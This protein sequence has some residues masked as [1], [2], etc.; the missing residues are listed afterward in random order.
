MLCGE[1]FPFYYVMEF[2]KSGGS[3]LADMIA[4]YLQVPRPVK[5]VL[6]IG[7]QA[8]IHGHWS[9]TPGLRRVFYIHR[10]GRDV[11]VS[12]YFRTLHELE[13]P[14][15]SSSRRYYARRFPSLFGPNPRDP[16]ATLPAFVAE[17]ARRPGG[18][19]LGW[20]QH[21]SDWAFRD[22]VVRLSYEDLSHDAVGVL[23]DALPRHTGKPIDLRKLETTVD[24]FSFERQTAGRQRGSEDRTSFF[25]KGIVGDW[26][27]H[28]TREAGRIFDTHFG[29]MLV[30]LGYER[31]RLWWRALP[32]CAA[33]R[34]SPVR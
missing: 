4:D 1:A 32:D 28:F 10:D 30:R 5:S 2:P 27:N 22:G 33:E 12:M 13:H 34:G 15:Y 23:A 11:A 25:R 17:F 21:I 3:W 7:T 19:R 6:P 8:V 14:S 24:K 18:T 9:Y 31:D 20:A 29:D 26:K 16:A